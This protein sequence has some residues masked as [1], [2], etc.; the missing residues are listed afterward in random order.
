MLERAIAN[1]PPTLIQGMHVGSLALQAFV[2]ST[3]LV[4]DSN[5]YLHDI[6]IFEAPEEINLP[7]MEKQI[8]AWEQILVGQ[9]RRLRER[10]A[11]DPII[12]LVLKDLL[13]N[14]TARYLSWREQK[15]EVHGP[16]NIADR[17]LESHQSLSVVLMLVENLPPDEQRCSICRDPYGTCHQDNKPEIAARI[18]C[19]HV[20]GFNC[21]TIWLADHA[22][23]PLCRRYC[24]QLPHCVF[25]KA[26]SRQL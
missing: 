26:A 4:N 22:S 12:D 2:T 3:T 15:W 6:F 11:A 24:T 17:Q 18:P 9:I 10:L 14:I 1:V 8:L 7:N 5:E 20:F 13:S 21:I 16:G 23:C 19:G 25:E